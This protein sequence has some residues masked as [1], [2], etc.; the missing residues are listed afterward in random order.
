MIRYIIDGHNLIHTVSPY[1]DLLDRSYTRALKKVTEDIDTYTQSKNVEAVLVFDGN[2]P[3]EPPETAGNLSLIFSGEDREADSVIADRARQWQ[4][5]QTVVVS[6]D[7]GIRRMAASMGCRTASPGEFYRLIR[8]KKR[9]GTPTPEGPKGKSDGLA[10]H[11]VESWKKE[12]QQ[13][14]AKK[15]KEDHR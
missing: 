7:G 10:P 12:I 11:Q 6:R 5:P 4:G 14:L 2:P 13:A 15:K 3:W 8:L 9:E 1:L